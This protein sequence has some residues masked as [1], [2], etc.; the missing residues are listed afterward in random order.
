[1]KKIMVQ[2]AGLGRY[3]FDPR[4]I[5]QVHDT[6]YKGTV[7]VLEDGTVISRVIGNSMD[8]R[9]EIANANSSG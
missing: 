6:P 7:V 5:R 9:Q 8:I 1:M 3:E 4:E 2:T